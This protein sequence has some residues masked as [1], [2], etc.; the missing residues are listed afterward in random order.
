MNKITIPDILEPRL[1][2]TTASATV[3]GIYRILNKETGEFYIG[4]S[5]DIHN[6]WRVHRHY[7]NHRKHHCEKLQIDWNDYTSKGFKF[8]LLYHIPAG[9]SA[10]YILQIEQAYLDKFKPTY[11]TCLI[12][13]TTVGTTRSSTSTALLPRVP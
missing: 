8:E 6:R 4:S 9:T 3:M 12:A 5:N 10:E 13:G 11:N 1:A 2:D 7:L